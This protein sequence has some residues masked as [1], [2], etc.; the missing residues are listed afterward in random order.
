MKDFSQHLNM[1]TAIFA[2]LFNYAL[3]S[4]LE[5]SL[6]E[7]AGFCRDF[8]MLTLQKVCCEIFQALLIVFWVFF[9]YLQTG[10]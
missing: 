9:F 4:W 5:T 2:P 1:G 8:A 10:I 3:F 7:M 6:L